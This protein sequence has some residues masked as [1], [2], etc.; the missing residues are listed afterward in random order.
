MKQCA[1]CIYDETTPNIT[2]DEKGICNYCKLQDEMEKE[3]PTGKEGEARLM[4]MAE[5]IKRAGKGKKYDCV[6]G[7]SGGCD[8]SYLLYLAK[9]KMG[10]R[11]IAVH[12]DNTW[13]SNTAVENIDLVLKKLDIP[14]W[15]FVMDNEEF[16]DLAAA[17]FKS[18]VPEVDG[19]SD[20]GLA[21]TLYLAAEKFKI[22]YILEGHSFRTEGMT[23]LGWLYYDAKYIQDI[24]NKFGKRKMKNYPNLWLGRWMKWM[25]MNIKKVR[26]LY[27]IEYD[28]EKVK[29]F[30][31]EEYGWK[32]YGGH[33]MENRFCAFNH[34]LLN[35]KYNR[36]FRYVE[37]SAL[38]RSGQITR[39][40][41]LAEIA[42]PPYYPDEIKREILKRLE[43]TEEE[44]ARILALP[45][46]GEK[47]YKTYH[48]TFRA[49]KPVFWVL[50]KTDRV[51][52]SF[53]VKYCK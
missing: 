4:K 22:K 36:D 24:H 10:L 1:R 52:K 15:T 39:E 9:V 53:Y 44:Y 14:L 45:L 12:F 23:P 28:K 51:T 5:E 13:N 26:P 2:F 47:D 19:L 50:Y 49:L 25:F 41:A 16:N 7:I 8:S 48:G 40:E 33:H 18:S 46:K 37:L 31:N 29:K 32:W 34:W 17:M 30:L 21:T 35:T 6:V 38:V 11:P 43:L 27:Y 20:I 3:Y 42:K